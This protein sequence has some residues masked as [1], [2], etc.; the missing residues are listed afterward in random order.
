MT[1]DNPITTYAADHVLHYEDFTRVCRVNR[2][3][4]TAHW[5]YSEIN[6]AV[7]YSTHRSWVYFLT[8]DGVIYKI[9]ES[10][11]PLGIETRVREYAEA[12]PLKATTNRLGRYRAGDQSDA[13]VRSELEPLFRSNPERRV[14]FWARACPV[15]TREFTVGTEQVTV[16]NQ[17]H[18]QLEKALLDYYLAQVGRYPRC[19]TG[20]C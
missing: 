20:R 18:K 12:Q 14:E 10:G 2:D 17:H 9:G 5:Y 6:S 8:V 13:R 19:N 7:L 15:D 11:N 3:P 4:L 1:L 16:E